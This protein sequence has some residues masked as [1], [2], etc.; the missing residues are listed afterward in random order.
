[1]R[2]VQKAK[3]Q[4]FSGM[5]QTNWSIRA[6]LYSHNQHTFIPDK[7]NYNDNLHI[8]LLLK[9]LHL[10][11]SGI[12]SNSS[13]SFKEKLSLKNPKLALKSLYHPFCLFI[14]AGTRFSGRICLS[15]GPIWL[16]TDR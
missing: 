2:S 7:M 8:K 10:N 9:Y 16:W 6:L 11:S 3:V 1:M 12:F 15:G 14:D 13:I 4:I 5:D